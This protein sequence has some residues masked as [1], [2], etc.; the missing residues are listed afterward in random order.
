MNKSIAIR[1]LIGWAVWTVGALTYAYHCTT[2]PNPED[3]ELFFEIMLGF[4]AVAY[5]I[6]TP[7]LT[8]VWIHDA[9]HRRR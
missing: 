1:V 5:F 4:F 6:G 3:K 2:Y 8:G 9:L 7:V